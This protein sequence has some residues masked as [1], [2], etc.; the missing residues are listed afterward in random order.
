MT[1]NVASWRHLFCSAYML[2]FLTRYC[3]QDNLGKWEDY[4]ETKSRLKEH[5]TTTERKLSAVKETGESGA[6]A[7][8]KEEFYTDVNATQKDLVRMRDL[9]DQ[10]AEMAS[11]SRQDSLRTELKGLEE[12]GTEAAAKIVNKVEKMLELDEKRKDLLVEIT[13][14]TTWLDDKAAELMQLENSDLSPEERLLKAQ[15]ISID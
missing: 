10:L 4:E 3:L 2:N 15:V 8:I 14:L 1:V 9:T 5:I 7:R 6:A 13:K 11:D 12:V